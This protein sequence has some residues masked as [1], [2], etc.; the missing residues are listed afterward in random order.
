MTKLFKRK[1]MKNAKSVNYCKDALD[2]YVFG[3]T[4]GDKGQT[5]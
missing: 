4:S 1:H 5:T 3:A 2:P